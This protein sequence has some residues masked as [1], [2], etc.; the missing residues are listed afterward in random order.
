MDTFAGVLYMGWGYTGTSDYFDGNMDDIRITQANTFG[1]APDAG[2]TDTITVPA[3]A[4]TSDDDTV[5]LLPFDADTITVPTAPHKSDSNTKLLIRADLYDLDGWLDEYRVSKGSARWT[6]NFTPPTSEYPGAGGSTPYELVTPWDTDDNIHLLRT[7]QSADTLYVAHPDYNVRKIQ[8]T[9]HDAWTVAEIDWSDPPWNDVNTTAITLDPDGLTGTVTV[10]ASAAFFTEQ[11][12]GAYFKQDTGFYRITV[13]TNA[14]TATAVVKRDLTDHSA[15]ATWYQGSWDD[16]Q[17]YP[18]TLAFHED[19]LILSGD[20]QH[21]LRLFLSGTGDYENIGLQTSPTVL[22]SDPMTN[23]LWSAQLNSI[24]WVKSGKKL[25]VGTVGSEFWVTGTSATLDAPLTPTSIVARHETTHGSSTPEPL[26]IG[27]DILFTQKDGKKVR[28]WAYTDTKDGY[29]GEDLLVLAEQITKDT[30]IE[31]MQFAQDPNSII[32]LQMADGTLAG[33]TYLKSHAVIGIARHTTTDS[34]DVGYCESIAVIPGS[35][36]DELWAVFLRSINGAAVRYI[37][38]LDPDFYGGTITDNAFF[39]DSGLS[40]L[41]GTPTGTFGGLS[42]LEGETVQ[43][44]ADGVYHGDYVISSGQFTLTGADTATDVHAG[45]GYNMDLNTLFPDGAGESSIGNTQK[46][47][48]EIA[49]GIYESGTG[50]EIGRDSS[51]LH[52]VQGLTSGS[53][54]TQTTKDEFNGEYD[55]FPAVFIRQADP[56]PFTLLSLVMGIDTEEKETD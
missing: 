47:V 16:T 29:E 56:L 26:M 41:N 18:S 43:V 24:K 5:L 25:F 45:L 39:V 31:K 4:H 36:G 34:S 38:R 42:H 49:M 7:V 51:N 22:D 2:L 14:T 37:E 35:D 3:A 13:Y 17:A 6:A 55:L 21:P 15:T 33:M 52:D 27:Q 53:L 10:T 8:R 12:V 54:N 28:G 48:Y 20:S 32:W 46:R 11:H 19:R 44:L 9:D 40:S 1:A 30:T 50:V 23:D